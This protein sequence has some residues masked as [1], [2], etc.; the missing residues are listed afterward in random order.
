MSW[1]WVTLQGGQQN[2]R[3]MPNHWF[4]RQVNFLW[5]IREEYSPNIKL[6]SALKIIVNLLD[7]RK[8][9]V[10]VLSVWNWFY[11]IYTKLKQCIWICRLFLETPV[12]VQFHGP[13]PSVC[14][15][16]N[17]VSSSCNSNLFSQYILVSKGI[18]TYCC[19]RTNQKEIFGVSISCGFTYQMFNTVKCFLMLRL[20]LLF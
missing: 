14:N 16:T 3:S 2:G 4:Q 19:D 1:N 12:E 17:T 6:A 20:S 7:N 15:R 8:C 18:Y 5:I 10:T 13:M 11:V 9:I